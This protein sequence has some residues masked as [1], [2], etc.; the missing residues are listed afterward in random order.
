M[1]DPTLYDDGLVLLD[2]EGITLR[3]YYFPSGASKRIPYHR[4]RQ[5]VVRPMGW[6]TGK[7]RGW[8]TAHPG[9]WYPLDMQRPRKDRLIVLD[10]GGLV[11]P[12]F[13]P[14]DPDRV[15]ELLRDRTRT[16]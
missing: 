4:I 8:G 9:Y 1:P 10:I 2:G 7:G 15:V 16:A 5:V 6:L 11:K 12:A 3:R 14:E 13:S